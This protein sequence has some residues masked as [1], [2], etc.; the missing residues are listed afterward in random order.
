MIFLT[1]ISRIITKN[2]LMKT[3]MFRALNH[4]NLIIILIMIQ[5]SC[6]E[7]IIVIPENIISKDSMAA[8]LTDIQIE[9]VLV[10]KKGIND[11]VSKDSILMEY[12]SILQKHN[13][14]QREFETSY[15]FYKENPE[16]L[17]EIYDKVINKISEMQAILQSIKA[18]EDSAKK[19]AP[20]KK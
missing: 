9:E 20:K 8:I 16:M 13:I 10:S 1:R 11:S 7:K 15:N 6:K 12:A 2:L 5:T 19:P 18:M 4:V 17:E 3:Y 14:T